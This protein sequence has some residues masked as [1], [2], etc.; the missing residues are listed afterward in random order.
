MNPN[1]SPMR[2]TIIAAALT[3]SALFLPAANATTVPAEVPVQA[4]SAPEQEPARIEVCFVLDTTGSMG[5]LIEGAKAKIW[6]IANEIASARPTPELKVGL[7]G[8]RDRRDHYVT[9]VTNLTDDLDAIYA[10]LQQF[11]AGGGGDTPE[12]VNQALHEAVGKMSWTEEYEVLKIV[13]LVGDSPPHMDY[14][15]DVKYHDTCRLALEKDLI[16]NT[17]QCGARPSTTKVWQEIARLA[18]G[19]YVAIGQD[20]GMVVPTTP[21]DAELTR[22]N[23]A[24]GQT[25][26]PYGSAET[27]RGVASKQAASERAP[28]SAAAD[29][30]AY[31]ATTARVVQGGGDLIDALNRKEVNL[32]ELK[33]EELPEEMRDLDEDGRAAYVQ[34][35]LDEREQ[36]QKQIQELLKKRKAYVK[37]EMARLSGSGDAFDAKVIEILR[38]QAARKGI[39]YNDTES[40]AADHSSPSD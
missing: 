6:S 15:D 9:K 11:A 1:A 23:V 10:E 18:E 34:T 3:A 38:E 8:F 36:I 25:I 14:Q 37:D 16:I 35:R 28:G 19:S 13:F 27:R 4:R 39:K 29:R 5:G 26:I 33:D 40:A 22:L 30:L 31:N 20:G 17:V 7:V 32:A 21:M 12:S 24:I 2:S